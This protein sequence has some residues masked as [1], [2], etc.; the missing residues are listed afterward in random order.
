MRLSGLRE[1]Q[2][3]ARKRGKHRKRVEVSNCPSD[4]F[5]HTFDG[6][7]ND[8]I[9]FDGFGLVD[10]P[11]KEEG[12]VPAFS[13]NISWLLDRQGQTPGAILSLFFYFFGGNGT[14]EFVGEEAFVD[15]GT[16]K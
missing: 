2:W 9:R 6:F 16:V 4:G 14:I 8:T 15:T 7:G 11:R 1:V 10:F 5:N 3:V 13:F 12:Y